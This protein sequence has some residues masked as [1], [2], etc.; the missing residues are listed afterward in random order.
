MVA[1]CA[2]TDTGGPF[3]TAR[4]AVALRMGLY[5][6]SMHRLGSA[7]GLWPLLASR[8][9]IAAL[10]LDGYGAHTRPAA[11]RAQRLPTAGQRGR[12][13]TGQGARGVGCRSARSPRPWQ[14]Q[15]VGSGAACGAWRAGRL[16]LGSLTRGRPGS[17]PLPFHS[18]FPPGAPSAARAAHVPASACMQGG[19]AV[20]GQH[21]ITPQPSARAHPSPAL[22]R[23]HQ[24]PP[25]RS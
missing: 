24:R 22:P 18:S 21:T 9:R 20:R 17:A 6:P 5:G 11:V 3:S 2:R 23:R 10:L 14:V 8:P 25:G 13:G 7:S 19:G 15:Q 4:A 12:K 1:P 16:Q